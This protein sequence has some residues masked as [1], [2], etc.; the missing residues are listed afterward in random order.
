ML[1]LLS[2]SGVTAHCAGKVDR[3]HAAIRFRSYAFSCLRAE[4]EAP[5]P[6]L[7]SEQAEAAPG[8]KRRYPRRCLLLGVDYLAVSGK[9]GHNRLRL[10][11]H[12]TG[13]RSCTEAGTGDPPPCGKAPVGGIT[14]ERCLPGGNGR[15]DLFRFRRVTLV[16]YHELLPCKHPAC[17]PVPLVHLRP[18]E[19]QST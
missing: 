7:H 5:N 17:I 18:A 13:L 3:A 1:E 16:T 14:G 10:F 15:L 11:T 8:S 19:V 4:P 9:P 2:V 12:A 6:W